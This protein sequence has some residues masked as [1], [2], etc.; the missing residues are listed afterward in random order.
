MRR[1]RAKALRLAL[2]DSPK[3]RT[4]VTL[5]LY[6]SVTLRELVSCLSTLLELSEAEH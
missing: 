4:L 1:A 3:L 5:S 2:A 6:I